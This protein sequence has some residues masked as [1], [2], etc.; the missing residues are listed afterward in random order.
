V[1]CPICELAQENERLRAAYEAEK[2][3]GGVSTWFSEYE[4]KTIVTIYG[5]LRDAHKK[6]LLAL[7]I[8]IEST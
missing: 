5:K 2:A 6:R 7:L 4:Q 1:G 8:E 3:K